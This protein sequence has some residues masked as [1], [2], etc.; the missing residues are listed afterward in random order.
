MSVS[1]P[2]HSEARHSHTLVPI[3]KLSGPEK[4]QLVELYANSY[5]VVKDECVIFV[6]GRNP[7]CNPNERIVNQFRDALYPGCEVRLIPLLYVPI[8]I[9]N[10]DWEPELP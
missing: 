4:K 2:K 7:M 8:R 3:E 10:S 1:N 6:R 9:P 5:W